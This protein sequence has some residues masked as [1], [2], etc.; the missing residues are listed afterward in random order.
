MG[1][2]MNTLKCIN[3]KLLIDKDLTLDKLRNQFDSV[4]VMSKSQHTEGMRTIHDLEK[5]I[6]SLVRSITRAEC[7][8]EDKDSIISNLQVNKNI[9]KLNTQ[10]QKYSDKLKRLKNENYQINK[11]SKCKIS[12]LN[13][14][15]ESDRNTYEG[16]ISNV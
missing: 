13:G 9:D 5:Q 10:N 12:Q 8:I 6:D 3:R 2:E 1:T 16:K 11:E 7:I 4:S 15:C 14:E